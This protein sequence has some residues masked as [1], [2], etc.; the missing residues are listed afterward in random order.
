MNEYI[1]RNIA[2]LTDAL[3]SITRKF[4]GVNPWW[5]G[6]KNIAWSLVPNLYRRGL[7]DKERNINGRFRMMAKAR[8]DN[9]PLNDDAFPWLF[10]MQ[11]YGLPTRLLDW[12]ESPLVALH[13][14][15]E[16]R[17]SEASDAV[18]WAL[19]P[20]GLN[21][22][23]TG[24]RTICLY[25]SQE[26]RALSFEAFIPNNENPDSRILS[27]VTEQADIRQMV[28]QSVFTIHG[29][30]TPLEDLPQADTYLSRMRIPKEN[31][32]AFHQ[33]LKLFGF[34]RATLF[35]D[36]ENLAQELSAL[37]FEKFD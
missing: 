20:S 11:H 23:Q 7:G 36:L 2:E 16:A 32:P 9:C 10:L 18:L 28:Q 15:L 24:K 8:Y 29:C 25:G 19:S 30:A 13:F 22:H 4:G 5:R 34:S 35:P 21:F 6:H 27:V 31:K 14:A 1:V 26:V 37:E 17:N 3:V 33:I 12:S